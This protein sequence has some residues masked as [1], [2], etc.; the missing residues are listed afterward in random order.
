MDKLSHKLDQKDKR[1]LYELD[2]N[3]RQSFSKIAKSVGL[4]KD[5][6][7]YRIKKLQKEGIIKNFRA[8]VNPLQL[9]KIYGRG[10]I[11]FVGIE[12]HRKAQFIDHLKSLKEIVYIASVYDKF[13]LIYLI[14]TDTIEEIYNIS[15]EI[16]Y[17]FGNYLAVA[18]ISLGYLFEG[19]CHS[20]I[21]GVND[22]NP[23]VFSYP[24]TP[25]SIDETDM[26]LLKSLAKDSRISVITLS[27]L[28][29]ITPSNVVYRIKKLE[30]NKM[31][32][33]Y[34]TDF[35]YEK[36]GLQHF[37]VTLFLHNNSKETEKQIKSFIQ[38][39]PNVIFITE[40][41]GISG[42]QFE[43]ILYSRN[44]L[45]D[46]IDEIKNSFPENIRETSTLT[47]TKIHKSEYI[48]FE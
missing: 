43:A 30:K 31:I 44:M 16:S 20:A 2:I 7:A 46:V 15:K 38:Q 48:A 27:R 23:V 3:S 17:T 18:D 41:I 24:T 32:V 40:P 8:L 36:L 19:Y 14:F 22:R 47:I 10:H 4:S 29:K 13:D 5:S 6:V 37:R 33:A 12:N 39:N 1:I 26:I 35:D 25:L 34:L 42:F 21:H 9:H 28:A 11:K 45:H